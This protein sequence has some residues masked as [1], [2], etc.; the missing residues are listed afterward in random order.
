MKEL[1]AENE[2]D[3]GQIDSKQYQKAV[4]VWYD[5]LRVN[6]KEAVA[7]AAKIRAEYRMHSQNAVAF[8]VTLVIHINWVIGQQS[9]IKPVLIVVAIMSGLLS[10]WASART[11]RSFQWAVIQQFYAAKTGQGRRGEY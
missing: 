9:Q 6:S 10:L 11:N 5:W 8:M 7:N 1:G 3:I 2:E 4:F